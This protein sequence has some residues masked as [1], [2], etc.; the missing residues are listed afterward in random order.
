MGT[1]GQWGPGVRGTRG[2]CPHYHTDSATCR[3]I[4]QIPS[5]Y[6]GYVVTLR[7]ETA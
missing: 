2:Q 6:I 4:D 1:R 7:S 5:L 3:L